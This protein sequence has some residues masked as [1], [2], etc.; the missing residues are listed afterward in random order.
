MAAN[1]A[2]TQQRSPSFL[3]LGP[4]NTV[5]C[6]VM[7]PTVGLFLLLLHNYDFA[8]VVNRNVSIWYVIHVKCDPYTHRLRTSGIY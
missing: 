1:H 2:D 5:P 8:T 4:F 7:T 3:M 6:A